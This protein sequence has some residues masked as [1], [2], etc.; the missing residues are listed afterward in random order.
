MPIDSRSPH[1]PTQL[2]LYSFRINLFIH[3][4]IKDEGV[5]G[6][7]RKAKSQFHGCNLMVNLLHTHG[8]VLINYSYQV[9]YSNY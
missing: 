8:F 6:T 7:R 5:V 3:Q 2:K 1:L 4:C 9:R